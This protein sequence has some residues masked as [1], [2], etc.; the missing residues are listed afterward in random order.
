MSRLIPNNKPVGN[1]Y[2]LCA[3]ELDV[4]I[5]I[6]DNGGHCFW[7][8]EPMDASTAERLAF[9]I[10]NGQSA[11][12]YRIDVKLILPA[13]SDVRASA[14]ELHCVQSDP[15]RVKLRTLE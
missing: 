7:F 9:N 13:A 11:E 12:A 3:V 14:A 6:V 15:V 2:C 4:P 1:D 10:M 5:V 8:H